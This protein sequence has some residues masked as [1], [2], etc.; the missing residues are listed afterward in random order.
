MVEI[1][2][3][4]GILMKEHNAD[5]LSDEAQQW[6]PRLGIHA[7]NVA[8]EFGVTESRALVDVLEANGQSPLCERFLQL[9]YDSKK[10]EKWMLPDSRA[11][12]RDRAIIAGHYVFASEQCVA[13]KAAAGRALEARGIDL[14]AH[15]QQQV[16]NNILRYLRNFRLVRLV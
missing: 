5:Y 9:A 10:W 6:H 16:K 15:L 12:D 11:S 8:P 1:C 7:A 13:L 14:E 3:R 4:Y 2:S